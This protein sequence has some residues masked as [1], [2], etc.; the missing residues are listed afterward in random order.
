MVKAIER[1]CGVANRS[2]SVRIAA[3]ILCWTV[4]PT[5]AAAQVKSTI[6]GPGSTQYPIAVSPLRTSGAAGASGEQF[7]ERVVRNLQLSG[8]FRVIPRD[9]YIETPQSSGVEA[10]SISFENWSVLGAHAVVKGLL[11]ATGDDILVEARLFD[12][13]RRAQISGRRYRGTLADLDRIAD[14][15]ADEIL[16]ALSGQRGPFD[17][18]IAFLS[19]RGGRFKELFVMSANGRDLRRLTKT[20]TLNLAPRWGPRGDRLM[21]TSYRDGDPDLFSVSY[22]RGEWTR[23][24]RAPGM[25]VG[26]GW[27]ADGETVLTTLEFDGNSEIALLNRDGSVQS[28]LTNHHAI[29][30][31]PTWSPDGRQVVFC[32]DRAGS[33]Q[34]YVMNRDGSGVRRVTRQG[35]YN[36]SPSWSPQGDRIAYASRVG[37]RF[38]VFVV[39]IDGG[40]AHQVTTY[41]NN[42]DPTWSPDGRYLVFSATDRSRR[43]LVLS[44]VSGIHRV[45]LTD[46]EGDDTSPSWS[47]WLD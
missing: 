28:R 34:I 39:G 8:L 3:F 11:T 33:P 7:A 47:G 26:G 31:S 16:D 20:Q 44:D 25:N 1:M 18:R 30:V 29:D 17:S 4:L 5:F 35:T 9:T 42:E 10:E 22:P 46:G 27:S 2:L 41:G 12:V 43:G 21:F 32:S 14:R 45:Q 19:T 38:Q 15:F 37:G 36:S 40:G 6:I 23:L 13:A 24:S